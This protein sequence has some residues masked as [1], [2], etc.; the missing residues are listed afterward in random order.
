MIQCTRKCTRTVVYNVKTKKKEWMNKT[1]QN[2]NNLYVKVV[3]EH[4]PSLF[5]RYFDKIIETK[6]QN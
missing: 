6:K 1:K 4:I 5:R 2:E 3:M